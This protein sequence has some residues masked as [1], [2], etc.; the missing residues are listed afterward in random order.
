LEETILRIEA[1]EVAIMCT[2]ERKLRRSRSKL[3]GCRRAGKQMVVRPLVLLTFVDAS[4]AKDIHF[5]YGSSEKTV[6]ETYNHQVQSIYYPNSR[7]SQH[8]TTLYMSQ[9]LTT[10]TPPVIIPQTEVGGI[11]SDCDSPEQ[12]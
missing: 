5:V 11:L 7:P 2:Y 8:Q 3:G 6:Q 12:N 10:E 4:E 1:G 9:Q